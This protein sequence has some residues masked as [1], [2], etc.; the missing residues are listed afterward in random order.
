MRDDG[1]RAIALRAS[2]LSETSLNAVRALLDNARQLEGLPA[3]DAG[4]P[5]QG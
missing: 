1:V 4:A 5:D 3:A 2:G